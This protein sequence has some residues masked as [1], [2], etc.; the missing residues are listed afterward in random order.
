[1]V[2]LDERT[3]GNVSPSPKK[4]YFYVES[5]CFNSSVGRETIDGNI[6]GSIERD[7]SNILGGLT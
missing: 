7:V 3:T 2:S 4:A 1:M 6:A 5:K